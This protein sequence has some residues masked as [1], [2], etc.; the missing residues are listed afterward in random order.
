MTKG[1]KKG[2]C[3]KEYIARPDGTIWSQTKY[4]C[5][6]LNPSKHY[7]K[8]YLQFHIYV[9]GKRVN[10]QVHRF[11]AEQLIPNP[12]NLPVVDH[13]NRNRLD[14]RV[15]NLRWSTR[16]DNWYNFEL[17]IKKCIDTLTRAGYTIIAP[18]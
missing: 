14:N 13:I 9:D 5:T 2:V 1:R 10:K 3:L 4:K 11:I 15:E 8:E 7:K 12:D 18:K 17:N 16:K 6:K